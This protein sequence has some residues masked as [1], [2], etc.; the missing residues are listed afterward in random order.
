MP[1]YGLDLTYKELQ[2][3]KE[4]VK[5]H[6]GWQCITSQLLSKINDRIMA[7]TPDEIERAKQKEE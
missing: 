1:Q 5:A 4:L 3:L 7:I 2:C 6:M